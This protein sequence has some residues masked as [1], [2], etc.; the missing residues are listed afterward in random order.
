MI[1]LDSLDD[2]LSLLG[3]LSFARP[4]VPNC[5]SVAPTLSQTRPD[6]TELLAPEGVNDAQL[7]PMTAMA[8]GLRG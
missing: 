2:C 4:P 5:A 3:F 1:S 7:S 8:F 6:G